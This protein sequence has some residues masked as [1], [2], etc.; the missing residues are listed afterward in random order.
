MTWPAFS[1]EPSIVFSLSALSFTFGIRIGQINYFR[2]TG[3]IITAN[4]D[5]P[6]PKASISVGNMMTLMR[7]CCKSLARES[8][9]M[10]NWRWR[11]GNC[12][13]NEFRIAGN[14]L[15][16]RH[17]RMRTN[18]SPT[19]IIL[20]LL[21]YKSYNKAEIL[22]RLWAICDNL[23]QK[24]TVLNFFWDNNRR[25]KAKVS[26]VQ[27]YSAEREI[28]VGIFFEHIVQ[29]RLFHFDRYL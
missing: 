25:R 1:I 10:W 26:L 6:E 4:Y 3:P 8:I 19:A 11:W 27:Y 16:S 2:L 29:C 9:V 20:F 15:G 14:M 18:S 17:T 22:Y 12:N 28:C 24:N 5:M 7:T 23:K 13:N 21:K